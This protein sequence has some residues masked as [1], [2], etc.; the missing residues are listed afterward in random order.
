MNRSSAQNVATEAS[1][2]IIRGHGGRATLLVRLL[3]MGAPRVCP[4]MGSMLLIDRIR[5][6]RVR[7]FVR[8]VCR[9]GGVAVVSRRGR[10]RSKSITLSRR[11]VTNSML[12]W[13]LAGKSISA[14]SPLRCKVSLQIL[15]PQAW[16]TIRAVSVATF[17][18]T[19]PPDG[20][21]MPLCHLL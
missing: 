7:S 15:S 3:L 13:I 4:A 6:F 2:P 11:H 14:P 21:P 5:V 1:F 19:P 9:L 10:S 20:R 12:M 8:S 16:V 18:N 17:R